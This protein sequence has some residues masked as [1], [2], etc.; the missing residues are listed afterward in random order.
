MTRKLGILIA[1]VAVMV[2]T[3]SVA[4]AGS[5]HFVGDC[6]KTQDGNTLT[7]T[8]KEAGLGNEE[9]IEVTISA[10]ALCINNGGKHPKAVNKEDLAEAFS[11]PVQ[12]GTADYTET[13]TA[14][15]QPPC[16]PPMEVQFSNVT[17]TDTTNDLSVD[18]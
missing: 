12:N 5:P 3:M 15:F 18:P 6:S 11:E 7:V 4:T 1:V 8:C 17:V 2:L 13:L 14:S 9:Q 10:T 16:D